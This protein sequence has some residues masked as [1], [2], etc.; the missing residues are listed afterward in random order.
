MDTDSVLDTD[1]ALA[2]EE[3]DRQRRIVL[4]QIVPLKEDAGKA[5]A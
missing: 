1:A 5:V 2:E 3:R 4:N